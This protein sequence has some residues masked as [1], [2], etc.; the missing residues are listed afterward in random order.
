M[1]KILEKKIKIGVFHDTLTKKGGAGRVAIE[2]ANHLDADLITSGFNLEL[3]KWVDIKTEVIDIGNISIKSSYLIGYN[4][5]V[6]LR[7]FLNRKNFD[8]DIYIFSG[9]SSI[10][11]SRPNKLNI[12]LCHTPNRILYDLR[13][14]RLERANIIKKIFY[15]IYIKI[16]YSRDQNIIKNNMQKIISVSK[17]VKQRVKKYYKRKA[18]IIYSPIDT[19]KFKF[20]KF[21]DFYLTVSRLEIEKRIDLIAKAFVRLPNKRLVI[22]GDGPEKKKILKVIKCNKNI[23][24]LSNVDDGKLRELYSTCLATI[25]M[26]FNE[27]FGL[28]PLEGMA[29]GKACIAANEGGCKETV[30]NGKTGFLIKATEED[31]VKVIKKFNQK[32]AKQMKEECVKQSKKFDTKNYIKNWKKVIQ[33]ATN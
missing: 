7:F 20:K 25:Y 9:F 26:P 23:E 21:G 28:V 15:K 3:K 31:I 33:N 24:L 27:D 8:Y 30:I 16:L 18:E 32:K 14:I 19:K 29:S 5:E 6:P 22:I 12:W 10:F 13:K 1:E 2:L 11:A 17:N 4:L